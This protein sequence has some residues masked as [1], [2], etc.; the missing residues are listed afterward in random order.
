MNDSWIV[1]SVLKS[2]GLHNAVGK[3]K[4]ESLTEALGAAHMDLQDYIDSLDYGEPDYKTTC[5]KWLE[6]HD[7]LY[8]DVY[9]PAGKVEFT[10][11]FLRVHFQFTK[12]RM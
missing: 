1:Y 2:T 3:G 12:D 9:S 10:Y 7:D 4:Y 11:Y 8:F 5:L 6:G